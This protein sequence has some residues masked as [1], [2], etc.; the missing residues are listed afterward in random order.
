MG[1]PLGRLSHQQYSDNERVSVA[2]RLRDGI[3]RDPSSYDVATGYLTPSVWSVLG[4]VLITVQH[5]RLLL[6]KDFE[7]AEQGRQVQEAS[8]QARVRQVLATEAS[9]ENLIQVAMTK[10]L[11]SVPLPTPEE[12]D[13]VRGWLTFLDRPDEEVDVRVWPEG[14]LHAKAH[15]LS[16]TAGVGSANFTFAG[17]TTN[18][19]LVAW[20][21]DRSVVSELHE[22]FEDHWDRAQPYK[23]ELRAILEASRFGRRRYTPYELFIRVLADRYGT[24]LPPSLE[25]AR[26]EL[27]WFQEDAVFRLI[28]L[29]RGPA[30]GAL[31]ADAVGL[32]K[33]FMALGVIHHF[34]YEAQVKRRGRGQ[35]VLLIVP[36]SLEPMWLGELE[37]NELL[38]ACKVVTL[39]SLRETVDVTRYA[40]ADL[41]VIDEAHRLRGEGTWFRKVME[42]I[43]AGHAE[44]RVLLLTATPVHTSLRDLTNLLRLM[45]KN[46]RDVW[47][48]AIPDFEA[49]LRRVEKQES[50]PF[51]IL[52]RSVVRRSRTDLLRAQEERR[53]AGAVDARLKLPKR[54]LQHVS[55]TYTR[56]GRDDIFQRFA[57]TIRHL[58]LAPY[59][60]DRFRKRNSDQPPDSQASDLVGLFLAGL[61]KRFESSLRAVRIS[62]ERLDRVLRLTGEG[63]S[64]SPS[65]QPDLALLRRLLQ[66]QS[67]DDQ[68]VAEGETEVSWDSVRPAF[69]PLPRPDEFSLEAALKSIN[70]DRVRIASLLSSLPSEDD[71]GKVT[72]LADMLRSPSPKG[73][74]EK[75]VLVFTQFRDTAEYLYERLQ[76]LT[77]IGRLELIHGG[78]SPSQRGRL[79][80]SFDRLGTTPF[81][82]EPIRVLISTDVLAEGHNLQLAQAVVNFDL[83]WN[84][85]VVVQRAGR[86]DRLE[87]PYETIYIHSF[88]PAEGLDAHLG[89]VQTLDQRFGLIHYLGLGDEPVTQFKSDYQAATF[90]QLRRLYGND[91]T[92]FD[93]LERAFL[94]GS[95]DYMREPLERF[96]QHAGQEKLKEIPVGVQSIRVLP[97]DWHGNAGTFIAFRLGEPGEGETVWRFYPDGGGSPLSDEMELFRLI[98][99]RD[100]VQ[101]LLEGDREEIID[102]ELLRRA[103]G[104]VTEEINRKRATA[105]LIRGASEK[106]RKL[107]TE[108]LTIATG[109]GY[110]GE[111]LHAV[112]DRLEEV[113]AEEFDHRTEYRHLQE[114]VQA[115]RRAEDKESRRLA[116]QAALGIA[117][118][119][120]GRPEDT[121]PEAMKP[122]EATELVL[123]AWERLEPLQTAP[124]NHMGSQSEQP[125]FVGDA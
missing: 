33:T 117:T 121:T 58:E 120:F 79:A 109:I 95:T 41:V 47:A 49:H 62:L 114:Q 39:Q 18:K 101:A 52:D 21:E 96:I 81:G 8:I 46:R 59:D 70:D 91:V 99:A 90:E 73:L 2:E 124:S 13:A 9:A 76:R 125:L 44:K 37:R 5:F 112:L 115:A 106:S 110:V 56:A 51:P 123:V 17:L 30:G 80:A 75:R 48:P 122:I 53:A 77:S 6:G 88:L 64:A 3:L 61:L 100:D 38:W 71:D 111:D 87:S 7:L 69:R 27:K 83:H 72:A 22:W 89:L 113:H 105:A 118:G 24:E 68:D 82:E 93:E 65:Q 57:D 66:Q 103:A 28:K 119:L 107:R 98:A 26:F 74:Q 36:A 15:L 29:L 108:L 32:G 20:R 85:Q 116:L 45:T 31:L 84:P 19:E 23:A 78:T 94:L 102:W 25:S 86:V 10:E 40:G 43:Q 67:M 104:Q 16:H 92:V 50:D 4:D 55:Y 34:L 63:L 11:E 97:K 1:R 12:A 35:P 14:F 54:R 42:I 60:L